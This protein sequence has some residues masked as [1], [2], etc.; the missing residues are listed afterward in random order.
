MVFYKKPFD[1]GLPDALVFF[2]LVGQFETTR[3]SVPVAA[4]ELMWSRSIRLF[5]SG[6]SNAVAAAVQCATD[7][8]WGLVAHR[9]DERD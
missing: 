5:M 2:H 6:Q 8:A 7:D 9:F 1:L 3:E 4:H